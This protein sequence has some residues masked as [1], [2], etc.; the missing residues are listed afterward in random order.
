[1]LRKIHFVLGW[2]CLMLQTLSVLDD[3]QCLK[4]LL[5]TSRR[6]HCLGTNNWR[7]HL[8]QD[9]IWLELEYTLQEKL[10][11][12]PQYL[13]QEHNSHEG[14]QVK[15]TRMK[16]TEEKAS[17]IMTVISLIACEQLGK[18]GSSQDTVFIKWF[19]IHLSCWQYHS[20]CKWKQ[21]LP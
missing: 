21:N 8:P 1:M 3:S 13:Y 6:L 17:C 14:C 7:F 2:E 4:P 10:S 16:Y 18:Q 5:P 19:R 11:C 9:I 12:Y 20:W 15:F